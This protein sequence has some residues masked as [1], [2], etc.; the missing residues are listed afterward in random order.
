MRENNENRRP[1]EI[2]SDIER[3]R[4]DFSSTIDAIQ[5]KLTPRELMD[6]AV[7]YALTTTPGAFSANL[8]N[9]VRDNPIPVALIGIGVAWLMASGKQGQAAPA[10]RRQ[11]Y[12]RRAAYYPEGD[13]GYEGDMGYDQASMSTGSSGDSMTHRAASKTSEVGRDMKGKA[14]EVGHRISDSASAMT[15][16]VQ[17]AGQSARTRL[18][19]TASSAQVRMSEMRQRSREQYYR[20]KDRV[21]Q[22]ADEQPLVLGALGIALGAALGALLPTTRRENELMGRTRDDLL[23][24]AKETAR[25]Q[26]DHVKQSAQRVAEAAKQEAGRFKEE[27]SSEMQNKAQSGTAPAGSASPGTTE[28]THFGSG[29]GQ[30]SIH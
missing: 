7:D 14:S 1:E 19:E 17:Q 20:T 5:S 16:R 27:A 25:E 29:P 12:A 18:Q 11:R 6:Q 15:D 26:A 10:M 30:Q 4:A 21:G 13:V 24:R 3:T 2:E 23:D 9:T 8:V 22:F 28:T